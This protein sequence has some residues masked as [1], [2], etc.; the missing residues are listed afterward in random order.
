MTD[1]LDQLLHDTAQEANNAVDFDA[2]KAAVLRRRR[3]RMLRTW[4]ASVAC[5]VCVATVL[6]F[7]R[8]E[9]LAYDGTAK[10]PSAGAGEAAPQDSMD[11]CGG[12][13]VAESAP[14]PGGF[15]SGEAQPPQADDDGSR[16]DAILGGEESS[17]F[18]VG[19]L[20]LSEEEISGALLDMDPQL[21]LAFAGAAEAAPVPP[22]LGSLELVEA[23]GQDVVLVYHF[24]QERVLTLTRPGAE[25]AVLLAYVQSLLETA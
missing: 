10:A 7:W 24:M 8:V 23:E 21:V 5:F 4:G 9:G 1:K 17:L 6:L 15:A 14:A 25:A 22:P 11:Q 12:L 18:Y 16:S 13:M 3:Q 19:T 2:M 20:D